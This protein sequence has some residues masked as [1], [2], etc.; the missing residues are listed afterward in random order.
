MKKGKIFKRER[1]SF[2][3]PETLP[4]DFDL[5]IVVN[6]P[7]VEEGDANSENAMAYFGIVGRRLYMLDMW[8]ES[9]DFN[10]QVSTLEAFCKRHFLRDGVVVE[11][12]ANGAAIIN[13][14]QDTVGG[15]VA[16]NPG[17][18]SKEQR[19][20]ACMVPHA[21]GDFYLP[22]DRRLY[23]WVDKVITQ[24]AEFPHGDRDDIVD[25]F[26]ITWN[27]YVKQQLGGDVADGAPAQVPDIIVV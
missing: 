6:D 22:A 20:R 1:W 24:C 11:K 15:V 17:T 27:W 4:A 2:W 18:S 19:A 25:L 10:D 5:R 13:T 26:S 12:K 7:N 23:P 14:I 16:Y 9:Q 3:E 21:A 8:S